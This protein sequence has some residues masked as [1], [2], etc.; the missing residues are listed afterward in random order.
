MTVDGR[1]QLAP[2]RRIIGFSLVPVLGLVAPFLVLPVLA[3]S[4]DESGWAALAVG[5]SI[6]ALSAL[7]V[8][9]GWDLSGPSRIARADAYYRPR[10]LGTSLAVQA[11]A[12]AFVA[13]ATIAF[14]ALLAPQSSQQLAVMM[15]L[16]A[17][18]QGISPSWY[19]IGL[20]RPS[21]LVKYQVA[22][23]LVASGISVIG[24]SFRRST[25]TVPPPS[26][27]TVIAR[28][29]DVLCTRRKAEATGRTNHRHHR[30]LHSAG[31]FQR[32]NCDRGRRVLSCDYSIRRSVLGYARVGCACVGRSVVSLDAPSR[33][34]HGECIPIL[35][36]SS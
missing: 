7:I 22:P 1:R 15:A 35:D 2:S 17:A 32:R 30:V 34:C 14:A 6:G 36:H 8:S 33:I 19:A 21:L 28:R 26:W 3:R 29:V 25:R 4:V 9:W 5:Q 31:S 13:P 18:I 20:G 11:T 24:I 23:K 16:A 10:L 12:L 27:R